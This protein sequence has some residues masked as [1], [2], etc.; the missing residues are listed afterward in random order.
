MKY[1]NTPA[2]AATLA[3]GF[4]LL[5]GTLV[6]IIGFDRHNAVPYSLANHFVSELGGPGNR[7][8]RGFSTGV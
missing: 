7:R 8:Q 2:I 4:V 6:A 5:A 3:G 1:S